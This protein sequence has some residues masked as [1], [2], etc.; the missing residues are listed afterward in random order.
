MSARAD[1]SSGADGDGHFCRDVGASRT[2]LDARLPRFWDLARRGVTS[3]AQVLE[4]LASSFCAGRRDPR[5]FFAEASRRQTRSWN[6][7]HQASAPAVEIPEA[8]SPTS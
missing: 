7:S 1:G 4:S 8:R 2:W 5:T 6:L 3:A